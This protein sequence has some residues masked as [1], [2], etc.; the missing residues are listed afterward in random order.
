MLIERMLFNVVAF[1]LFILV[2]F[3]MVRK[4]DTNI[5]SILII[6]A[7]GI[8]ISFIELMLGNKEWSV[9]KVLSYIISIFLPI[10]YVYLD[11]KKINMIERIYIFFIKVLLMTNQWNEAK[12][13][14]IYIT[15]KYPESYIAHK[16]LAEIYEKEGKI[17]KA[18]EEYVKA[19][20]IEKKDYDSYYKISE[21]L[22]GLDKKDEAI[23]ML[24][25]LI[26]IKPDYT[27]AADLLGNLLI[28]KDRFKEAISV[29]TDA[30][31]Y[32]PDNYEL[33]YGLG[34]AYTRINDFQNAK[35]AYEKAAN[36]NH[37]KYKVS[38]TLG[39]IFLIYNDINNAEKYF[40]EALYGEEVE[41]AAYYELAKIH[42]IK[43]NKEKA[44]VFLEKAIEIDE[45]YLK[46]L[47]QDLIFIP[48]RAYIKKVEQ[49]EVKEIK[50]LTP[51]EI[52]LKEHLE[53]TFNVVERLSD[54]D[55]GEEALKKENNL[56]QR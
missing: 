18:I 24:E 19:I 54:I 33:Y 16:W 22:N 20:D 29:Y 2:F 55:A 3:K 5:I 39:Q 43:K 14:L 46:K 21:L 1:M 25:S 51:I 36:I 32:N 15:K 9:F 53:H 41:A 45:T 11:S 35:I 47:D 44:L 4:N 28:E 30:L 12:K 6:Q 8:A 40:M 10:F 13:K 17:R 50:K 31:K 49:K 42:M 52:K 34:I 23:N 27:K 37:L 48:I 26:K 7:I 38:Y 56:K